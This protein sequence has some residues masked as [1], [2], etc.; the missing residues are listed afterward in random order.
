MF[1]AAISN[2]TLITVLIVLAILI[3]VVWL[4]QHLR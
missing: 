3:A 2:S 4:I 1:V